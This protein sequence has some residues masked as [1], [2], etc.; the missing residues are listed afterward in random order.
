MPDVQ[1]RSDGPSAETILAIKAAWA[2]LS[3][4]R[5]SLL[6]QRYVFGR[7][8]KDIA[9]RQGQSTATVS[10]EMERAKAR[11]RAQARFGGTRRP[12]AATG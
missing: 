8:Q 7:T 5:R 12:T 11:A 3:P 2:S 1:A 9:E 4:I 10:R 6:H